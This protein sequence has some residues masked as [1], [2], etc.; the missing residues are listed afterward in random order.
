[1]PSTDTFDKQPDEYKQQVLPNHV[2][3]RIAIEA[4]ID[5]YWRKYVGLDGLI[6]GMNSFGESAPAKQL[7]DYFGFTVEKLISMSL[8][9]L[10][11]DK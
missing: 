8:S 10:Q 9:L 5:D 11:A 2:R 4:S 7:F 6:M 1:M 3:Q